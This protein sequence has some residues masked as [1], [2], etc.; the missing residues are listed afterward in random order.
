MRFYE[1]IFLGLMASRPDSGSLEAE[2]RHEEEHDKR[3]HE[4]G[5]HGTG[6]RHH[7]QRIHRAREEPRRVRPGPLGQ[8]PQARPADQPI[9]RRPAKDATRLLR[10]SQG[11]PGNVRWTS[12]ATRGHICFQKHLEKSTTLD[13]VFPFRMRMLHT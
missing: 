11:S 1:R 6:R 9:R 12:R 10:S 4:Q 13:L 7:V 2:D 3:R 5:I 8:K